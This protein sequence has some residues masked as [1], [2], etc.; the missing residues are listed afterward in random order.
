[1]SDTLTDAVED[2]ALRHW[3]FRSPHRIEIDSNG[4][5][6]MFREL[7]LDTH[8]PYK[9]AVI[10]WPPLSGYYPAELVETF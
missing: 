5:K 9:P 2:R 8:S 7:L 3:T 10:D 4:H 1:M 6:R